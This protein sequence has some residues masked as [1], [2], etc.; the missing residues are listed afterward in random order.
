MVS[1]AS[2]MCVAA[3]RPLCVEE[4]VL[5]QLVASTVTSSVLCGLLY[6]GVVKLLC[7]GVLVWKQN[8][9][10]PS[11][12]EP[13]QRGVGACSMSSSAQ[14]LYLIEGVGD[15]NEWKKHD[16]STSSSTG[17]VV[18]Q[19]QSSELSVV[20]NDVWSVLERNCSTAS[21]SSWEWLLCYDEGVGDWKSLWVTATEW[22]TAVPRVH[23]ISQ[24]GLVVMNHVWK[25]YAFTQVVRGQ[26]DQT[27]FRADFYL[28]VITDLPV[29]MDDVWNVLLCRLWL[30]V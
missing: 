16:C 14:E 11:L 17:S 9:S 1:W 22:N 30:G 13:G 29:V 21:T 20:M 3:S 24:G 7:Y 27:W 15:C 10:T 19:I 8:C 12:S 25:R 6:V 5:S 26:W 4:E 2:R 18:L 23:A 28:V